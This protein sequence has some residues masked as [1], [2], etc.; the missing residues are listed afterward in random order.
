MQDGVTIPHSDSSIASVTDSSIIN[1]LYSQ[2]KTTFGKPS[3][4]T[5]SR[6]LVDIIQFYMQDGVIIPHS[7]SSIAGVTDSFNANELCS[8]MKTAFGSRLGLILET[9]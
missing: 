8:Q 5:D 7:N 3:E 9:W 1:E 4:G 2:M 6:N